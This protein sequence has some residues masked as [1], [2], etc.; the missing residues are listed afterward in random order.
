MAVVIKGWRITSQVKTPIELMLN[1]KTGL[2][3]KQE[4][5]QGALAKMH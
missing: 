1:C 3:K 4:L 2:S 5:N